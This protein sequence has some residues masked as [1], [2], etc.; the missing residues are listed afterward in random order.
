MFLCATNVRTG[1]VKVF[2]SDEL[3]TDH[4]LAS[5]CLPLLMR[6]IEI[7]GEVY[8]DGGYSGNPAVFPLVYECAARDI[9]M[10]H[11]TPAERPEIPTTSHGIMNRMQEIGFN[12][13]LIREMRAV[14]FVNKRIDEGR[15]D[16][17]KVM[18]IHVIEAE[19]VIREFPGSSRLNNN[20]E[21]LC[22]LHE[23]GRARADKWLATNFEHLGNKS[24]VD[25]E[26]KYF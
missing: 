17:G 3:S 15:M 12:A 10:V 26:A 13:A 2:K 1:K 16:G 7:D 9:V 24:T 23:V 21:F 6:P 18:L 4:V 19:D 25:L 20:W 5:T 11:L 8:W 22:H 14:A